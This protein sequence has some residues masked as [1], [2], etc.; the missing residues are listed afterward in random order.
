MRQ[1]ADFLTARPGPLLGTMA[2]HFG[3]K[4]PVE[5]GEDG[6]VI[7]FSAG[8]VTARIGEGALHLAI[9]AENDADFDTVRDVLIRHL[10]RFAH[11]EEPVAPLWRAE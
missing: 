5:E 10:L 6:T 8:T 1:I 4:I 7:R 11:R 3:H 2:K 9:E